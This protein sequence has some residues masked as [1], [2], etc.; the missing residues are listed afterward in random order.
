MTVTVDVVLVHNQVTPHRDLAHTPFTQTSGTGTIFATEGQDLFHD[1]R[2]STDGA[3]TDLHRQRGLL[4]ILLDGDVNDL[5]DGQVVDVLHG[6]GRSRA[7]DACVT[8]IGSF[9]FSAVQDLRQRRWVGL[10]RLRKSGFS[11]VCAVTFQ[12][13]CFANKRQTELV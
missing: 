6:S 4:A 7:A 5:T 12:T 13:S 9:G 1:V 8:L 3:Q 11:A 10:N 2:F